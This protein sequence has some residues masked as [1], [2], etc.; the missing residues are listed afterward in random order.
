MPLHMKGQHVA[1]MRPAHHAAKGAGIEA[2]PQ[3]RLGVVVESADSGFPFPATNQFQSLFAVILGR[4]RQTVAL[5]GEGGPVQSPRGVRVSH[6]PPLT[7]QPYACL[8][9]TSDA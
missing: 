5:E 9:Y 8:L 1:A 3:A 7:P 6:R 4:I 2:H